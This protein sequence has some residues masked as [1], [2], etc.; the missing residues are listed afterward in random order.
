MLRTLTI[1]DFVT[2]DQLTLDLQAG[3]S[4]LTGET[5]AGKSILFD[6][7]G[8]ILGD[9]AESSA[10][11]SGSPKAEV[12]A[13][14]E[15]S[16]A[17]MD[18]LKQA[19]DDM[20]LSLDDPLVL[21]KRSLETSGR[22]RAWVNGQPASATQLKTLG[23]RLVSVHGQHAHHDLLRTG[24]QRALLDR[25]AGLLSLL[26]TMSE[27]HQAWL[28][29]KEALVSAQTMAD[30]QQQ[31]REDLQWQIDLL[32][33]ANPQP[34][35]WETL[36]QE[37]RTLSHGAE[38]LLATQEALTVLDDSE[39]PLL[40][41]LTKIHARIDALVEKDGRLSAPA[42]GM[43]SALIELEEAV[44]SL[45]RYADRLEL[46]PDRLATVE[47]RLSELHGLGRRLRVPPEGLVDLRE[48]LEAERHALDQAADIRSLHR[49][50][51]AADQ[52][53]RT[54]G[55]ELS[56]RRRE[57]AAALSAAVT[58]W[59]ADLS[60]KGSSFHVSL[61]P[62]EQPSPSGFEEVV[63]LLQHAGQSDPQPLSRIASGGELSR[64]GL[65]IA[66][67]AA[68][69]TE[70]PTLLFDEVDAGIGGNTGHV[71]GRLLR[72][73]GASHQVLAVTHLPQVAARAHHHAR[74]TKNTDLQPAL[75]QVA[76][77]DT[78][79][80]VTEIARMLGD[81]GLKTPSTQL[82]R[83]LLSLNT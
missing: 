22:S 54:I 48:A 81:E 9:R 39:D 70:C 49:A 33:A 31:R 20:G 3:F 56:Q 40:A 4:A 30:Q 34:G 73:L 76:F 27:A 36:E 43:Q 13:E 1:K 72:T 14:F 15:L 63:F 61:I 5:G 69:G 7:L 53:A 83:E 19:A 71:V 45:Q 8:L 42:K 2:V 46:D 35:E 24:A 52:H 29:C 51:E 16:P 74:V 60:M 50:L 25:Q 44:A 41:R 65:A 6:A 68:E 28:A 58:G 47:A 80:R 23:E 66:A 26:S 67:V 78:E 18:A 32:L 10:I 79:E 37:Q 75:S 82:A 77:L 64:I 21:L 12:T 57:A 17:Q 59:L 62:R 11:R 38:L 55:A